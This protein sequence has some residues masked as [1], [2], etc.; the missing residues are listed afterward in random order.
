MFIP[1]TLAQAVGLIRIGG[2][3]GFWFFVETDTLVFDAVLLFAGVYC[4]RAL[5][6]YARA[7]PLFVLLVLVFLMTASPMMYAVTNFGTLFRLR[8]MVY[9]IAA[10][11]PLTLAPRAEPDRE[12]G[13]AE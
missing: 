11:L 1:R 7:T 4:T 3:R 10:I 13:A 9:F 6:S 5:R 8:L 2:G 12:S